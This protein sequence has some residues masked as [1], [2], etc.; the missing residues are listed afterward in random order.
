MARL[1]GPGKVFRTKKS[2]SKSFHFFSSHSSSHLLIRHSSIM[3]ST[4][5]ILVTALSSVH[6]TTSSNHKFVDPFLF[7]GISPLLYDNVKITDHNISRQCRKNLNSIKYHLEI[8]SSW[9]YEFLDSSSRSSPGLM[10]GTVTILGDYDQCLDIFSEQVH[11]AFNGKHC[12]IEIAPPLYSNVS[13]IHPVL[14][15]F[16]PNFA[17]CVPSTCTESDVTHLFS[18]SKFFQPLLVVYYKY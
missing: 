14:Q 8:G 4:L 12:M 13:R 9:A 5:L 7:T 15:Y 17:H 10:S 3:M 6:L 1:V 16:N 18:E 2:S 11:P